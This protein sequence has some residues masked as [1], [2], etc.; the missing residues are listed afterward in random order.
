METQTYT[1]QDLRDGKVAIFNDGTLEEL[2]KILTI[3]NPLNTE[4]IGQIKTT[5]DK[6]YFI[7]NDIWLSW[8]YNTDLPTQSVKVFLK[9][10]DLEEVK[11]KAEK[12]VDIT[13]ES[14][15]TN[16]LKLESLKR[17]MGTKGLKVGDNLP[18]EETKLFSILL[19]KDNESRVYCNLDAIQVQV[20]VNIYSDYHSIIVEQGQDKGIQVLIKE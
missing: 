20:K 15:S 12:G 3:I 13:F 1:I 17:Q 7:K 10:I 5:T 14:K 11:E 19:S 8:D 18:K 2:K 4:S 6:F 9:E 16:N